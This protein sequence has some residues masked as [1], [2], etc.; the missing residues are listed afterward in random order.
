MEIFIMY[1]KMMNGS[2]SR[3]CALLMLCSMA[4]A[5][6]PQQLNYQAIVRNTSGD[7]VANGTHV[8]FQFIIH[9]LT[10]AGDTV[11]REGDTATANQFG[12]VTVPIGASGG[13][14]SIVNWSSG[15]KFLQVLI[16]A[17]GGTNYVDMGTTQLL[18]VPYALFAGNSL[19]GPPGPTG[20]TGP[21]GISGNPGTT[22]PP[23]PTGPTGA[24]STVL[25]GTASST[26]LL[27]MNGGDIQYKNLPVSGI[28]LISP[29][30]QCWKLT[31][32]VSGNLVTQSIPCP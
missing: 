22:G 18:S 10:P 19:N 12:L 4:T 14:L 24:G 17:T 5:Q 25:S 1:I 2:A 26:S 16:D 32:D 30:Q 21:T 7:P 13:N 15:N 20:P 27:V 23:G 8:S 31:V 29:N 6:A 28:V 3:I 11:F 9:N